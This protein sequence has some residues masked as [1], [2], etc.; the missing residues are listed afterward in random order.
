LKHLKSY[1]PLKRLLP[2]CFIL[3]LFGCK[4]SANDD[5]NSL[6]PAVHV[7]PAG[8]KIVFLDNFYN[9][10]LK[11]ARA[12]AKN[13]DTLYS[14]K[15]EKPVYE[16]YFSAAEYAEAVKDFLGFSIHDTAGIQNTIIGIE[17]NREKIENLVA[18]A[19]QECRKYI[20]IEKL[21]VFIKP[22]NGTV[23]ADIKK[24][25][26]IM[27][28][29]AGSQ[30]IIIV[31]DPTVLSWSTML[32][33][34][35]ANEYMHAYCTK[36]DYSKM[37]S[38]SLLQYLVYEG[39]GDVYAHMIFPG[40]NVPWTNALSEEEKAYIW[41]RVKMEMRSE[42]FYL[43]RGIMYGNDTYPQWSG[44]TIGYNMMQAA[45]KNNPKLTP[46]EWVKLSPEKVLA[47]SDYEAMK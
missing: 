29:T 19:L 26:G 41:S 35:I 27:S 31:I 8:D 4:H 34:C 5:A 2:L 39:K 38:W 43:N 6:K 23:K 45:L 47:M 25:G 13:Y 28:L 16:N 18:A 32:E 9:A 44:F 12:G 36:I 30:Q 22:V 40:V 1:I 46:E 21:S 17:N 33:Y 14:Q 20:K 42:E 37:S 24:T 10:Y 11:D 15:I 7:T 3:V